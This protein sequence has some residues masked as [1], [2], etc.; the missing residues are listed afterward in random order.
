[1]VSAAYRPTPADLAAAAGTTIPD[2]V[3]P[4]LRVLFCGINPGLWSG[5]TGHHFARPGNRFWPALFRSGFTP[6]LFR[7]DEQAELLALGLGITNVVPRTTA[8]AD[9]LTAA[10]LREGGR[11]LTERVRRYRPKAL[12][13]L[14]IGAYRTA[15]GRPRTTVGRQDETIADTEIWVLPNPSGLNAHYTLD[16]LA[17]EFRALREATR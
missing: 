14:G 9:E 5:A 3:G 1:M 2:V 10:E 11:A 17:A 16:A 6:R 12:A 7:P 4:D 15:F 13:V 8:K